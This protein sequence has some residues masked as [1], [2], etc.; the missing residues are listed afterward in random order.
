MRNIL[1]RHPRLRGVLA[2]GGGTL[3]GQLILIAATP[4]LSRLYPPAA[5]G[6]FSALVAVASVIGPSAA[7]KFDAGIL[8]PADEQK[9]G[10]I[11]RLAL[12]SSVAT[13]SLTGIIVWALEL[14][15]LGEA[16]AQVQFAPLWIAGLVFLAAL[17]TILT[18][19]ALRER[20]YT[21][22]ARRAPIQSTGTSV[23][24]LGLGLLVPTAFGLLA[25]FAIGRLSGMVALVRRAWPLIS[26]RGES[27]KAAAREYWRLPAVLA[28]SAL[29]NSLG[30][31]IPLLAMAALFG[32][33]VAGEFSMAQRIVYIPVTLIGASVAQ[34]FAAELAKHV[35]EGGH[36]AQSTYLR[37]SSR[38]A[39][40]ALPISAAIAFIGPWALPIILGDQWHMA[41]EFCRPLAVVVGLSL[42][43]TPTSQVYTVFQ[44]SIS[45]LIDGSRIV[46]LATALAVSISIEFTPI[47]TSWAIVA[48]QAANYVF[49]WVVGI[50]VA[51][52]GRS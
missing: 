22:V 24:Q 41:G 13:S 1:T 45:L 31:Q 5:F 17:F 32:A 10:V 46:L 37:S 51:K 11:A 40:L 26:L 44:S 35:R 18:Q 34:V 50:R 47:E 39:L 43:A 8:L 36:G 25:G 42:I 29:M 21:L 19:A 52:R 28:P 4:L 12:F 27:W 38:L 9:A 2:L 7:L 33:H 49:T 14:I 3:A 48:A 30:S 6:A 20:A 16:W 23:G 15:G